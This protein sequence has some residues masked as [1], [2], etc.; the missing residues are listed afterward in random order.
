MTTD[1]QVTPGSQAALRQANRK[2]VI[3][4]LRRSGTLTQAEIARATGLSAASVSNIVRDLR[5]MGVVS[6]R[7]TSSNGAGPGQSRC[8]AHQGCSSPLTSRTPGSPWH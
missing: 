2:R 8:G 5:A 6:V 7:E 3:A 4:A 1:S